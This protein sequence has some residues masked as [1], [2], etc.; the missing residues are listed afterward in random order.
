MILLRLRHPF[1]LPVRDSLM[2]WSLARGSDISGKISTH[3]DIDF[4]TPRQGQLEVLID[5][6]LLPKLPVKNRLTGD[7]GKKSNW[8][9]VT[10]LGDGSVVYANSMTGETQKD[11]PADIF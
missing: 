4:A 8:S 3:V 1:F 5:S 9:A 7:G 11:A 10:N 6:P 2:P